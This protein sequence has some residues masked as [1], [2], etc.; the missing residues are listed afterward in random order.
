MQVIFSRIY[1]IQWVTM[2]AQIEK[3]GPEVQG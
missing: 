2:Y 3:Q 1:T